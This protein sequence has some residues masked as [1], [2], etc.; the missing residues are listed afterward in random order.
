MRGYGHGDTLFLL[1]SL[2]S[3][4]K[5]REK[6]FFLGGKFVDI[7]LNNLY[8]QFR[9][10]KITGAEYFALKQ[11]LQDY[12]NRQAEATARE[13]FAKAVEKAIL[14]AGGVAVKRD[15]GQIPN[16]WITR[17][18][19]NQMAL[20]R[21]NPELAELLQ[22]QAGIAVPD[23]RL[24]AAIAER[25]RLEREMAWRQKTDALRAGNDAKLNRQQP[26]PDYAEA[27]ENYRLKQQN[28][29]P[30]FGG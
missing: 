9:D 19:T 4:A 20:L 5:M 17:N 10:E 26:H 8:Q 15:F 12:R 24:E 27:V 23:R 3:P 21:S 1:S 6:S 16:P 29:I 14:G 11:E 22:S 28:S 7:E 30:Y 13:E 25:E 2:F 18:M